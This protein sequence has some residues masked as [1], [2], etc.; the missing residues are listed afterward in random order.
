MFQ[1]KNSVFST[2]LGRGGGE[3]AGPCRAGSCITKKRLRPTKSTAV[4]EHATGFKT[5]EGPKNRTFTKK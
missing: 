5:L 2:E 3:E 1:N 4:G